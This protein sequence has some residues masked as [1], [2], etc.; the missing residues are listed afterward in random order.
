MRIY[1]DIRAGSYKYLSDKGDGK[2]A[3]TGRLDE[4]KVVLKLTKGSQ[5]IGHCNKEAT[6]EGLYRLGVAIGSLNAES[7]EEVV[8][9]EETQLIESI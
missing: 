4:V 1:R 5:T 3:V 2:M 8:K 6:D 9:V 7:L